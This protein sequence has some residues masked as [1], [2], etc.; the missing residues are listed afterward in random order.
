MPSYFCCFVDPAASREERTLDE[1]CP[2]CRRAYGLPLDHAPT[3]ISDYRVVGALGRGFYAATYLAERGALGRKYVL[4]VVPTSIYDFFGKD[5]GEECRLHLDVA[6]H[7]EHLVDIVD[8]LGPVGAEF[9][10]VTIDCHVAVLEASRP[11]TRC[12]SL[13]SADLK[14]SSIAS[15]PC[16]CTAMTETFCPGITPVS[17]R[18]GWRSSSFDTGAVGVDRIGSV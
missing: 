4:K 3:E 5:F 9:G 18:P 7:S 12:S 8:M 11:R 2:E 10:D 6:E 16:G 15:A 14:V 17:S 13:P 1:Q